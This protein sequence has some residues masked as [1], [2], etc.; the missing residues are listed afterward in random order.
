MQ[1]KQKLGAQCPR[2]SG[3]HPTRALIV[4]TWAGWFSWCCWQR[5]SRFL[6]CPLTQLR[7]LFIIFAPHYHCC[8]AAAAQCLWARRRV[9]TE[10]TRGRAKPLSCSKLTVTEWLRW[11]ANWIQT[12]VPLWGLVIAYWMRCSITYEIRTCRWFSRDWLI[13]CSPTPHSVPL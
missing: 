8:L 2:Y 3:L 13:D 7:S 6:A 1:I 12:G 5:F 10:S 4:A 9:D 11:G